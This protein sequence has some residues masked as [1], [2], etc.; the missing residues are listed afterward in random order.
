MLY[1]YKPDE[2]R[3]AR[4]TAFWVIEGLIAY[5]CLTLRGML[6][7][8]YALR[9]PLLEGMQEIPILGTTLNLSLLVALLVF[10]GGTF[11]WVRFLARPKT[12]DHLIEVEAELRKVTWPS[13]KEASNS[14]IVVIATVL[15]L[16]LF[17][18][19]ADFLLGRVFELILW[20]TVGT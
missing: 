17:F 13:F 8:S 7:G 12:A 1:R 9:K 2:G 6:D 4:Q 15:V 18:M 16:L 20:R 19:F 11:A 5:G 10:L 14:S 3:N